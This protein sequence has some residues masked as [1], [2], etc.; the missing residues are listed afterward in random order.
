MLEQMD[1]PLE[2]T[3]VTNPVSSEDRPC[4]LWLKQP[5]APASSDI[6]QD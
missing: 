6:Q 3:N 4:Y 5:W 1:L 2:D